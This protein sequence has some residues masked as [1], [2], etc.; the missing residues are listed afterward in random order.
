MKT[1]LLFVLLMAGPWSAQAGGP[2]LESQA[3]IPKYTCASQNT[4]G[5][6]YRY[7][8][9]DLDTTNSSDIV[10][11]LHGLGGSEETWFTQY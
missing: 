4:D 8:F 1:L 2:D 6:P 9:R 11:F 3:E 5:L 10:F 7:C